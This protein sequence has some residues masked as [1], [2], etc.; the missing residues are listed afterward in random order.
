M[1]APLAPRRRQANIRQASPGL[2]RKK[3]TPRKQHQR[4]TER[5]FSHSVPDQRL[6]KTAALKFF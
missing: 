6:K 5:M 2:N 4:K 1:T 3:F